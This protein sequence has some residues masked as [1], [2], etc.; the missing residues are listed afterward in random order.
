M[1]YNIFTLPQGVAYNAAQAAQ[2]QNVPQRP[3]MP[4]TFDNTP[5]GQVLQKYIPQSAVQTDAQAAAQQQHPGVAIANKVLNGGYQP[6]STWHGKDATAPDG[7][8]YSW[9]GRTFTTPQQEQQYRKQS[10]ARMGIMAVA[11]ALR[12]LGN[13]YHTTQYAPSQQFNKPVEQEYAMYKANKAE[14]DKDNYAIQQQQLAQAKWEAEQ[15]YRDWQHDIGERGYQL[16]ANAAQDAKERNERLDKQ[17]QENADRQFEATRKDKEWE[18]KFKQ[19]QQDDLNAHRDK[20]IKVSW[21]N[22]THKGSGGGGGRSG[23]GGNGGGTPTNG[24]YLSGSHGNVW[25][26]TQLSTQE[27]ESAYRYGRR[28][29]W[30]TDEDDAKLNNSG[31]T[32]YVFN[33][34]GSLSVTSG[35]ASKKELLSK[36]MDHP[37]GAEYFRKT[38]GMRVVDRGSD[39]VDDGT[40]YL[41]EPKSKPQT[42]FETPWSTGA[43]LNSSKPA[44][45]KAAAPTKQAAGG[46]KATQNGGSTVS[47]KGGGSSKSRAAQ[48]AERILSGNKNGKD[49][50]KR[51]PLEV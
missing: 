16:K 7:G 30:I 6:A 17:K 29:G 37:E 27:V 28:M 18:Q 43:P 33:P 34:D 1:A 48:N 40:D 21:Y 31:G 8:I 47:K 13:I 51:K 46:Q 23:G 36:M 15:A 5:V 45:K 38:F 35:K 39:F 44:A 4:V 49:K 10:R 12:H 9:M 2:R 24:Y 11:D 32:N 41:S 22:A 14:R 19:K 50:D 42:I 20:Q 3:A 25:R 26:K